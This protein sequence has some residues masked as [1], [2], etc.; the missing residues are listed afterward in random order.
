[1]PLTMDPAVIKL[2]YNPLPSLL[3]KAQAK[4]KIN[5]IQLNVLV[6]I[7]QHWLEPT[8]IRFPRR[9]RLRAG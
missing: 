6:Q 5:P 3:L 1:V 2:G 4:L 9:R 7:S 8:K